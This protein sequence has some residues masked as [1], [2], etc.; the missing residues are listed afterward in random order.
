MRSRYLIGIGYFMGA[1]KTLTSRRNNKR[2]LLAR[3]VQGGLD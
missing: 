3:V 1:R 2:D